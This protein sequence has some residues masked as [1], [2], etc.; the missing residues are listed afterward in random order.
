MRKIKNLRILV[1]INSWGAVILLL[2]MVLYRNSLGSAFYRVMTKYFKEEF[3]PPPTTVFLVVSVAAIIIVAVSIGS[4][5]KTMLDS[6]IDKNFKYQINTG[7]WRT[8][9]ETIQET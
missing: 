6:Q 7:N 2:A 1:M 9:I 4:F 3:L 5:L 8:L